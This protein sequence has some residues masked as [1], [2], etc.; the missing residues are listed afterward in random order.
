MHPVLTHIALHVHDLDT[1]IAFYHDY[2]GMRV[3]HERVT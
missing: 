1:A 3:V 2:C